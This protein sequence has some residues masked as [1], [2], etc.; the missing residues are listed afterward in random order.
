MAQRRALQNSTAK[1][2]TTGT[3]TAP[4]VKPNQHA[5]VSEYIGEFYSVAKSI[6]QPDSNNQHGGANNDDTT[7]GLTQN[8]HNLAISTS[9]M[10]K[11]SEWGAVAYLSASKYGAGVNTQSI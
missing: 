5:N 3:R 10:L 11:N 2:E 6:G 9:H 4:T 7:N 1:F 8:S